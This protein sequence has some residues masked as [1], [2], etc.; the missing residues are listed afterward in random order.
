LGGNVVLPDASCPA[1]AV[2]TGS[3]E[4]RVL[5]G[6]MNYPRAVAGFQ[7]RRPADRPLE[8]EITVKKGGSAE[9]VRVTRDE[10]AALLPLPLF[11]SPGVLAGR[12]LGGELQLIGYEVVSFGADPAHLAA[13]LSADE[14]VLD[15]KW[16]IVS[17]GRMLVK[18]AVGFASIQ[19]GP[20]PLEDVPLLSFLR[21]GNTS[22][23]SHWLGSVRVDGHPDLVEATHTAILQFVDHP[24]RPE[25]RLVC[26]HV[27]LFANSGAQG[28]QLVVLDSLRSAAVFCTPPV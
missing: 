9:S 19:L 21:T 16:D 26:V 1:C 15:G 3:I 25:R 13:S 7:S 4:A 17:F 27:K 18:I 8:I 2:L 20:L 22:A 10:A 24:Q 23:A 28:Y 11:D 6:F 12:Q 5:R 14:V